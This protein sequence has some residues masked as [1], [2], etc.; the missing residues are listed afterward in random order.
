MVTDKKWK[1]NGLL[2]TVFSDFILNVLKENPALFYY[3][4]SISI[5]EIIFP[6]FHLNSSLKNNFIFHAKALFSLLD[7][8]FSRS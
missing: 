2:L 5:F 7:L 4:L 3:T 8:W 1:V 6:T